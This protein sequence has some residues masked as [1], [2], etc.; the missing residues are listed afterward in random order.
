[1][2]GF[3]NMETWLVKTHFDINTK[4]ELANVKDALPHMKNSLSPF[5]RNYIDLGLIDW[6]ELEKSI[7]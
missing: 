3:K 4:E 2:N 7:I 5:F 1:M 6:E